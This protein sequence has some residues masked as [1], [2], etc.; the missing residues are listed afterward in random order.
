MVEGRERGTSIIGDEFMDPSR[1]IGKFSAAE[2]TE[3]RISRDERGPVR[4][5]VARPVYSSLSSVA[6]PACSAAA[7]SSVRRRANMSWT[8]A[9]S[10][11]RRGAIIVS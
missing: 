4:L 7:S 8:D 10:V 2:C 11:A 3:M 9:G 6:L 1:G 5:P